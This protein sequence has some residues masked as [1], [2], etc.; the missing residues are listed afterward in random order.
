MYDKTQVYVGKYKVERIESSYIYFNTLLMFNYNTII[1]EINTYDITTYTT[2]NYIL[3]H[4][5]QTQLN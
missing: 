5:G 2:M 4:K 3:W 1:Y